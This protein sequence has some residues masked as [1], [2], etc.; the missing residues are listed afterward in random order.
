MAGSHSI[1]D[2]ALH[3]DACFKILIDMAKVSV[4]D[5]S[6]VVQLVTDAAVYLCLLGSIHI[7]CIV[8]IS[9]GVLQ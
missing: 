5:N 3:V 1:A 9:S 7:L 4:E 2:K 6:K 8:Y